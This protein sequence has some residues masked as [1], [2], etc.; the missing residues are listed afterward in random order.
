MRKDQDRAAPG[1]HIGIEDEVHLS[2]WTGRLGVS[3][4]ELEEAVDAVGDAPEAVAA[5]LG[6][7][8]D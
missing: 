7:A 3:R 2:Y 6:V 8:L 5:Y 1:D 4:E